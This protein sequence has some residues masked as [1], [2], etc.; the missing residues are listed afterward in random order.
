MSEKKDFAKEVVNSM[1]EDQFG[2]RLGNQKHF[3]AS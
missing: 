1:D 2:E 3:L